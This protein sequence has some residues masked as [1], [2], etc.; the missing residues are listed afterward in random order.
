VAGDDDDDDYAGS[1]SISESFS[2][3][4]PN[5]L[6]SNAPLIRSRVI[7]RLK[8]A[9][10]SGYTLPQQNMILAIVCT[11]KDDAN[12]LA[13]VPSI[14]GFQDPSVRNRRVFNRLIDQMVADGIIEKV[15]ASVQGRA[16]TK[17]LQLR[18]ATEDKGAA[19]E[20]DLGKAPDIP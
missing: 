12:K 14:Q 15:T 16:E 20:L 5:H 2:A 1:Q 8:A 13:Y 11:S 10:S 6:Y 3:I 7:K 17:C 19:D 4:T 18:Q 9:V